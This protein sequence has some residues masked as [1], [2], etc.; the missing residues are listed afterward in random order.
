MAAPGA[1]NE[2]GVWGGWAFPHHAPR[3]RP[4]RSP[5]PH[6]EHRR[7]PG[8]TCLLSWRSLAGGHCRCPLIP[9]DPGNKG[10]PDSK[11]S[12]TR[13]GALHWR[14]PHPPAL[15]CQP[16]QAPPLTSSMAWGGGAP[17]PPEAWLSHLYHGDDPENLPPPAAGKSQERPQRPTPQPRF[18]QGAQCL[19]GLGGGGRRDRAT[20]SAEGAVG[21]GWVEAQG[22]PP[23]STI[24]PCRGPS[25][26]R[27]RE[28]WTK[29][30]PCSPRPLTCLQQ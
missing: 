21:A 27:S 2:A 4:P 19:P 24:C 17:K 9:G 18:S 3:P 6:P 22:T 10:L 7:V 12:Q 28:G 20:G 30:T 13:T 1:Q 23:S 8:C 25:C 11:S 14:R 26:G 5:Q 15:S 16:G 29:V